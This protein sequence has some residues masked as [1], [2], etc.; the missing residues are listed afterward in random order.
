MLAAAYFDGR[1]SRRHEVTLSF[2]RGALVV[3]G[4]FG[5]RREYLARVEVAEAMGAAPRLLRFADGAYCEV[6][7]HAGLAALLAAGGW[8][9][10]TVARIQRR[11]RWAFAALAGVAGAVALVYWVLLPLAAELIAPAVPPGIAHALSDHTLAQ[12][13]QHLLRPSKLPPARRQAIA[14]ALAR[15]DAAAGPLPAHRL[16][17]RAAPD[18]GPN[19]FALPDGQ[20]VLL[21]ELVTLAENDTQVVAV[22]AHE[23]GHVEYLHGMRQLIQGAVVSFVVGAWFGDISSVAAGLGALVLESRYSREFERDADAYAARVLRAAGGDAEPLIRMLTRLEDAHAKRRGG[24]SAS[25]APRLFDSHPD[26]E[27]RIREIDS[28]RG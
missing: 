16:H 21:D 9:E 13:D 27:R 19:A 17:F 26:V 22:L 11:W 7:D 25:N 10:G 4:A 28:I 15:L 20:I 18:I 5:R 3:A 23:L 24:A 8:R 1:N 2:E 14:A 12:L 6:A